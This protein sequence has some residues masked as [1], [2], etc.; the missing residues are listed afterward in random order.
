MPPHQ[1][2]APGKPPRASKTW[3]KVVA[4]LV[5]IIGVVS[6]AIAIYEFVTRDRGPASYTGTV[7]SATGMREFLSFADKHD[8][9]LVHIDLK[10]VYRDDRPMACVQQADPLNR[11][12]VLL[13]LNDDPSCQSLRE[14]ACDGS[15][16]L[17]LFTANVDDA[18]VDNGEY[19]AGSIVVRGYFNLSKRGNLGTLPPTTTAIYLTA[20]PSNQVPKAA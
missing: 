11:A 20:V 8:G 1:V 12:A 4:A 10:C 2:I 7:E 18:Q 9:E 17:F 6:G 14:S 19:G 16:I 13:D 3:P 15:V 5:S